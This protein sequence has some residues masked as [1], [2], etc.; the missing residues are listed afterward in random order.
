[1]RFGQHRFTTVK[2]TKAHAHS[3]MADSWHRNA[4]THACSHV[5]T[6]AYSHCIT[7][8]FFELDVMD[9]HLLHHMR[10]PLFHDR[11]KCLNVS[12]LLILFLLRL[13]LGF[14]ASSAALLSRLPVGCINCT[15]ACEE[16]LR[17]LHRRPAFINRC[18]VC[19]FGRFTVQDRGAV[20]VSGQ[21]RRLRK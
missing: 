17:C 12:D 18:A 14:A 9:C 2:T 1:M 13:A 11:N 19:I 21:V 7:W 3:G 20:Y 16:G 5:R 10:I 15:C 8:I 4:Q 6:S